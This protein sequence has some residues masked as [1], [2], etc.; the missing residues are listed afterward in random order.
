MLLHSL[1]LLSSKNTVCLDSQMIHSYM[2][3]LERTKYQQISGETTD[4][5]SQSR[6]RWGAFWS[7]SQILHYI[8]PTY[9]SFCVIV[10][11]LLFM[12]VPYNAAV[13]LYLNNPS[14]VSNMHAHT[15]CEPLLM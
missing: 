12:P 8:W 9:T 15:I 6:I 3:H 2:E 1:L 11:A 13:I 14:E 5:A 7:H 10:F 4:T